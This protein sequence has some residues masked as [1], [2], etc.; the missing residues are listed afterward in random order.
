MLKPRHPVPPLSV[1]TVSGDVWTLNEPA[2]GNFTMLVFYRGW[3]CPICRR[4]LAELNSR[5]DAFEQRGVR[6]LALSMDNAERAGISAVEWQLD[7]LTI[8]YGLDLETVRA[9]G[10]FVSSSRGHT[11]AGILEPDYFNEPGLFLIRPD[12]TLYAASIQTMPFARPS[13]ADVLG[14][15][16]YVLAHD[17]PARGE[18]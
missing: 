18:V 10:L 7:R 9:W 12:G 14:A 1:Q 13:F 4:T 11:S 8:G 6:V 15:I 5:L 17:Y 2:P 3:H 16:D